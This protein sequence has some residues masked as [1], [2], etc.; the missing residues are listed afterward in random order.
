MDVCSVCMCVAALDLV[1]YLVPTGYSIGF[2]WAW[3]GV[4]VGAGVNVHVC[5][6]NHV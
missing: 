6:C 4:G 1:W 3:V 5:G 2:N